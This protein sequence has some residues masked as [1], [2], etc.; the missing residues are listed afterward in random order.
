[1]QH[2]CME[3]VYDC[4]VLLLTCSSF[5]L[6]GFAGSFQKSTLLDS[7]APADGSELFA[8]W[9]WIVCTTKDRYNRKQSART[10]VSDS[11]G[12]KAQQI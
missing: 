9:Q 5:Q 6:P 1:M 8:E 2:A 3:P 11:A 12:P 7:C 4:P 10:N